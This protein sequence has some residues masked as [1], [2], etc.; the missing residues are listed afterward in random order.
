MSNAN[1][2]NFQLFISYVLIILFLIIH[3]R[4]RQARPLRNSE[5]FALLEYIIPGI[6]FLCC[7]LFYSD[8]DSIFFC[9]VF[10]YFYFN[11]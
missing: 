3:V 9:F 6:Q 11:R 10:C 1:I 5:A 4:Y 2:L 7:V 8:C